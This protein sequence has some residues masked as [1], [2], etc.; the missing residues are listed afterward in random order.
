VNAS[1][2]AYWVNKVVEAL[3]GVRKP[4]NGSQVLV[5]GVTYK[6]NIDDLRESPA[7][8]VIKL[9]DERGAI[10]CFHDPFVKSL[11]HE[12]LNTPYVELTAERLAASDCVLVVTNHASYD[13]AWVQRQ[14]PLIVDSRHVLAPQ[15]KP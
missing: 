1:M 5:L 2:P 14:A 7:L 8:D 13:W 6:P 9:L 3:N 11:A 10:T 12:G 15:R 4:L